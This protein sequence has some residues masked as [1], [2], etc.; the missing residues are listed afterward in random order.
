MKTVATFINEQDAITHVKREKTWSFL[1]TNSS[2]IGDKSYYRCNKVPR[3]GPQ[4]SARLYILKCSTS[5][6]CEVCTTG[7]HTH[8]AIPTKPVKNLDI[9]AEIISLAKR[10]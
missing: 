5:M 10:T 7:E 6:K 8:I 9:K 3:K 1:Y 4:C 2:Q